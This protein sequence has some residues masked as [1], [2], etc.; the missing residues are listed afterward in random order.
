MDT[1]YAYIHHSKYWMPIHYDTIE[2]GQN[3]TSHLLFSKYSVRMKTWNNNI[4]ILSI[5]M[6]R[7]HKAGQFFPNSFRKNLSKIV[8]ATFGL[9][10]ENLIIQIST[11]KSSVSPGVLWNTSLF[12]KNC[13]KSTLLYIT[14]HPANEEL[15]IT[16]SI[17]QI[18]LNFDLLTFWHQVHRI[19]MSV[20]SVSR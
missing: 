8:T 1:G 17:V 7:T 10:N 14:L 5:H 20:M 4:K 6:S 13:H 18:Y 11:N 9:N 12:E 2:D 19:N 15:I 16:L 3:K